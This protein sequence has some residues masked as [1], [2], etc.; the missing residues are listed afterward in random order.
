EADEDFEPASVIEV[1]GGEIQSARK[2]NRVALDVPDEPGGA[3]DTHNGRTR[4][5][6]GE[7]LREIATAVINVSGG[8]TNPA[9][10]GLPVGLDAAEERARRREEDVEEGRPADI[11]S[12]NE[13]EPRR[14]IDVPDG[15]VDAS[16]ETAA[17]NLD[18]SDQIMRR[19]VEHAD[20]GR[21]ASARSSEDIRD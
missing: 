12:D 14:W 20:E 11:G 3:E 9:M 5:R 6:C 17:V 1:A 4:L 2:R 13:F 18:G 8:D 19:T 16:G 10:V 15:E 21:P 7:D